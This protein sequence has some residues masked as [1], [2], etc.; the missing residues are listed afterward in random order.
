[1]NDDAA[2][3]DRLVWEIELL[4]ATAPDGEPLL[5]FGA[6]PFTA[7]AVVAALQLGL[8]H[9]SLSGLQREVIES[10]AH[11]VADALIERARERFGPGSAI[12]MTLMQGFELAHD[13]ETEQ[14]G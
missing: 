7:Y 6:G 9:P 8:R 13:V 12:E 5:T 14:G 3:V 2:I 1:M 4:R 11:Q 10:F